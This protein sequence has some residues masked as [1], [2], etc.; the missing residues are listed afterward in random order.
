MKKLL[1]VLA[2]TLVPSLVTAQNFRAIA[3]DGSL[4]THYDG[5]SGAVMDSAISTSTSTG[6][7]SPATV[8][9][10]TIGNQNYFG[11]NVGQLQVGTGLLLDGDPNTSA[12]FAAAGSYITGG[13]H[14]GNTPD[15]FFVGAFTSRVT[16]MQTNSGAHMLFGVATGKL[17][18]G[19]AHRYVVILI[20]VPG[21][22]VGNGH[23]N[24]SSLTV[25]Q[26]AG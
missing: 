21:N 16:W 3:T 17:N 9:E 10:V 7:T 18:G 15:S 13:F 12:H 14:T 6:F 23:L 1:L 22:F 20:S 4:S 8:N 24:I 26:I 5:G 19:N 2:L 11:D 25:I